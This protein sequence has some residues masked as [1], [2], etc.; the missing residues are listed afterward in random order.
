MRIVFGLP[1]VLMAEV[2]PLLGL[3]FVL[4]RSLTVLLT[5]K[6]EFSMLEYEFTAEVQRKVLRDLFCPS[7]DLRWS[8]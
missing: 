8:I 1:A 4:S 7:V 3:I 5:M 6:R 2:L